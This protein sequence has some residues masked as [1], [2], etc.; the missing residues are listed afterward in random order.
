MNPA[1]LRTALRRRTAVRRTAVRHTAG[2][3]AVRR[4]DVERIRTAVRRIRTAAIR[5]AVRRTMRGVLRRTL[6]GGAELSDLMT[7]VIDRRHDIL[8]FV[9]GNRDWRGG[10]ASADERP[11]TGR[12]RR[13]G[14]SRLH[15]HGGC[16]HPM[17]DRRRGRSRDSRRSGGHGG[18]LPLGLADVVTD[19]AAARVEQPTGSH[20]DVGIRVVIQRFQEGRAALTGWLGVQHRQLDPERREIGQRGRIQALPSVGIQVDVRPKLVTVVQQNRCEGPVLGHVK[21]LRLEMLQNVRW[22][23]LTQLR[24]VEALA[25]DRRRRGSR[26]RHGL[27]CSVLYASLFGVVVVCVVCVVCRVCVMNVMNLVFR[28]PSFFRD[29]KTW[30][31]SPGPRTTLRTPSGAP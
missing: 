21:R 4:T 25:S 28:Y 31:A 10:S 30:M 19:D 14:Q 17:R 15:G 3:T 13:V 22:D 7:K 1:S 24:V 26:G 5:T 20:V 12:R 11:S 9:L 2:R 29:K 23:H 16:D 8:K 6:L 27:V 18:T